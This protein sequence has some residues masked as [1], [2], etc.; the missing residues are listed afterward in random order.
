MCTIVHQPFISWVFCVDVGDGKL[1][2]KLRKLRDLGQR[3]SLQC[4]LRI[5]TALSYSAKAA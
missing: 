1:R 2:R 4:S 5:F 3:M